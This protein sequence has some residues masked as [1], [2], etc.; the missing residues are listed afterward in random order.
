MHEANCV[1]RPSDTPRTDALEK[2]ERHNNRA[3][4]LYWCNQYKILAKDFE[5]RLAAAQADLNGIANYAQKYQPAGS[6]LGG[7]PI[8]LVP[9]ILDCQQAE[10]AR[11]RP[12]VEAAVGLYKSNSGISSMKFFQA[13]RDYEAKEK[14]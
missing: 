13:V 7:G 6:P 3:E 4:T 12:V 5:S 9:W 14:P 2:D 8:V 10:I 1:M 11:M